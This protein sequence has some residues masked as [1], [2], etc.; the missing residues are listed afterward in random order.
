MVS[1]GSTEKCT[2]G[3][4]SITTLEC[5]SKVRSESG[6]L[7]YKKTYLSQ[8]CRVGIEVVVGFSHPTK[9][10]WNWWL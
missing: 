9:K 10:F 8:R 2:C 5:D 4:K 1:K 7:G 6:F 3:Q